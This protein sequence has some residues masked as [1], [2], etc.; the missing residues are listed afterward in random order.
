MVTNTNLPQTGI[1]QNSTRNIDALGIVLR[2]DKIVREIIGSQS[3]GVSVV[4]EADFVRANSYLDELES[5]VAHCSRRPQQ[6]YV[7]TYDMEIAL[8]AATVIP[9]MDNLA[10]LH[11]AQM[12][13]TW[14]FEI[15]NSETSRWSSGIHGPDGVRM[16]V[17]FADYRAFFTDH[18]ATQLPQDYPETVP[19]YPLTGRG[20]LGV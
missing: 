11:L 6:D 2:M 19:S 10:I 20:A 9:M 8:P 16:A 1:A 3:H 15:A 13:D 12:V 18:I 7:K 4:R 5:F 17:W 14:R